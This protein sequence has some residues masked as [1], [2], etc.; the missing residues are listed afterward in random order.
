MEALALGGVSQAGMKS[1]ICP[2]APKQST[3]S[4]CSV[5]G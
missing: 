3:V 2:E 4:L 5:L 1:I